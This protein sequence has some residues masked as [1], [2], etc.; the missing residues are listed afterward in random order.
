MIKNKF[1]FNLPWKAII[2][3]LSLA[4]IIVAIFYVAP[5]TNSSDRKPKF[6][7]KSDILHDS[8]QIIDARYFDQQRISPLK[9]LRGALAEISRKIPPVLVEFEKNNQALIIRVGEEELAYKSIKIANLTALEDHLQEIIQFI[10]NNLVATDLE[11]IKDVDYAAIN[12][13][14]TSLDPHSS[15]LTPQ[16]YKDFT[17]DA[18]GAYAGVGMLIRARDGKIGVLTI[19]GDDSP[20]AKAGLK[21]GDLI[22]QIDQYSTAGMKV[23]DAKNKLRGPKK[24]KVTLLVK[25]EKVADPLKFELIRDNIKIASV[26]SYKFKKPNAD[27]GYIKIGR[28]VASSNEA[29]KRHLT[30]LGVELSGFKGLILDLR[31]NP[32]GLLNQAIDISNSF[33]TS[34]VI[35]S[36]AGVDKKDISHYKA[37]PFGT[38]KDFPLLVL[39]NRFSASAA[40][41]IAG[42]LQKNHRAV[43]IGERT[44]GKGTVQ[45]LVER[46]SDGS[47]LKLT[48]SQ[49]L[50]PGEESIQS[51]GI[52]PEINVIPNIVS[53][54]FIKVLPSIR[55]SEKE[56]TNSLELSSLNEP[57]TSLLSLNYLDVN[58]LEEKEEDFSAYSGRLDLKILKKDFL[59]TAAIN[60]LRSLDGKDYNSVLDAT[61][62]YV[63]SEN[64]KQ[65]EL[66]A[67]ALKEENINWK[68]SAI[69]KPVAT[70]NPL[71]VEFSIEKQIEKPIEK[72]VEGEETFLT[73]NKPFPA[74]TKGRLKF[75]VS[76]NST[77]TLNKVIGVINP[78]SFLFGQRQILFGE[79]LPQESKIAYIPFE[80]KIFELARIGGLIV[81]FKSDN[82]P[83]LQ[84]FENTIAF[85]GSKLPNIS[86]SYNF[87]N[88]GQDASTKEIIASSGSKIEAKIVMVNNSD[89]DTGPISLV[90]KNGDIDFISL[91]LGRSEIT[92]I[93]GREK[94]ETSLSIELAGIPKDNTYDLLFSTLFK[95]YPIL[96]VEQKI[97][98]DYDKGI[99]SFINNPPIIKF[100]KEP[101]LQ[102][103]ASFSLQASIKDDFGLKDIYVIH[104]NN[105]IFYSRL[106][107]NAKSYPLSISIDLDSGNNEFFVIATDSQ[108]VKSQRAVITFSPKK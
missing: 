49:Y 63:T 21:D 52:V 17:S 16:I 7:A 5:F 98:L 85:T 81:E 33:L 19:I 86:Y 68:T 57:A 8:L 74:N 14:L 64:L 101:L 35:V 107:D 69:T 62:K 50:T 3:Y 51:V 18:K 43:I 30:K 84:I 78:D 102:K 94:I 67:K 53:T 40:E 106:K 26:S 1:S 13:I 66:I 89:I 54:D 32:G 48:I 83:N 39:V 82:N 29:L 96:N 45:S 37:K 6:I 92:N 28:E 59:I 36:I 93:K 108:G 88:K 100:T 12:G 87:Q 23:E 73:W 77:Q 90:I 91:N 76:N 80:T 10:K 4:I 22:L 104:N 75:K 71:V 27:I 15:L 31:N 24:S 9:M 38:T 70:K 103:D 99:A 105:K 47:G 61:K 42:A 55:K 58:A 72:Q 25:R 95:N 56:L 65:A 34:G 60:I 44:F 11:N 46:F 2:K 41:I 20:S 97:A 79:I